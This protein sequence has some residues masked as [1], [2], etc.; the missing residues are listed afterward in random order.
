MKGKPT[1]GLIG[2]GQMGAAIAHAIHGAFDEYSILAVESNPER[3]DWMRSEC[4]YVSIVSFSD[5]FEQ[6]QVIFLA[7]KPQQLSELSQHIRPYLQLNHCLVSMVAG[8]SYASLTELLQP[9]Q[10]VRIMPNTPAKL[11]K[12]VT[13]IYHD[14]SVSE[15][16][17]A[18]VIACCQSFGQVLM[19]DCDHDMDIIT[20]IS[21]S[22]PAFFYR[23]VDAF[24]RFGVVSGLDDRVAKD[25]AIHTMIGAGYMLLNDPNPK[26]QI[27]RVASPNG[28]TQ[29][30]L[31]MMDH[32]EFDTLM[33]K[34]L[35]RSYDR[36]VELSKEWLC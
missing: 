36:A 2:F 27:Q 5:L 31:E 29:A 1:I 6:C 11:A 20:A 16:V 35:H 26:D 28:T 17:K 25:A 4:S 12:G 32:Q 15:H 9:A 34:V 30:G 33:E 13:G 3:Q 21:G 22:G 23:M 24:I 18:L 7:V 14:A 10:I 19:L 8:V